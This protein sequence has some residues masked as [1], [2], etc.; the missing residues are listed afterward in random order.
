MKKSTLKI[1]LL[2]VLLLTIGFITLSRTNYSYC[3]NEETFTMNA[4][5]NPI[6]EDVLSRSEERRVGKECM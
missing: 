1:K 6:Y 5:I 3:A 4:K 2:F